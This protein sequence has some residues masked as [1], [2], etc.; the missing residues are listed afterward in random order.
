MRSPIGARFRKSRWRA[1]R[2][3]KNLAPI[4]R[5]LQRAAN[6]YNTVAQTIPGE[7]WRER[8]SPIAWSAAEVTA[9]VMMVEENIIARIEKI[10]A[11]EPL[12]TPL[13]KR[14]HLPLALATWR[15]KKVET[16]IPLDANLIAEKSAALE[17]L[18][19]SRGATVKFI[20]STRT[21]DLSACRFSHL[22]GS[23]NAYDWFRLIG[24][25]QL[26]H[27]KQIREIVEAL[28]L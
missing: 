12:S 3:V 16:P 13:L 4:L 22:L 2:A 24:Y 10:A 23:L 18:A 20:E 14:F 28:R 8:P 25:H 6:D 15:G 7:R 27:A 17:R 5:H 11:K 1:E 19:S 21:Q 9:H 26:R